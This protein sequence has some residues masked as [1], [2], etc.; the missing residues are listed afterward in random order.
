MIRILWLTVFTWWAM[1]ALAI[2]TAPVVV[3]TT[4]SIGNHAVDP[5]ISEIAVQFDQT[6]NREHW[7]WCGGGPSYPPVEG[8]VRYINETTCVMPV[9]LEPEHTYRF[10]VNCRSKGFQGINGLPAEVTGVWFTTTSSE[11]DYIPADVNNYKAWKEFRR[12]F[13]DVY[14]HYERTGTDWEQ[15]LDDGAE[16]VLRSPNV[17]EWATR[18]SIM[19]GAAQDPHLY[20][21]LQDGSRFSTYG[22]GARYNGNDAAL[23]RAFPTLV[24]HSD[25]V[26]SARQD[27]IGYLSVRSWSNANGELDIIPELLAEMEEKTHALI[28]DVRA[29]GGGGEDLAGK[30]ATWFLEN[31]GV[32]AR[33][34]YRDTESP[35]GWGGIRSRTIA[36]NPPGQ[37]YTSPVFVLQGPVCLSSNEAFLLMMKLAPRGTSI[38]DR[39]GGSSANPRGF[40]LPNGAVIVLPR[41]QSLRPDGTCFEGEGI[42]PDVMITGDFEQEDPVLEEALR[43]ARGGS[44]EAGA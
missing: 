26:W 41:W 11:N 20:L 4:P 6:M 34:R 44:Q 8:E 43:R 13:R 29:N 42:A 19:L 9:K 37:R 35:S 24:R 7:S 18:L 16:W 17:Q 1:A 25:I 31:D 12:L 28:L 22:R 32:Y 3:A 27:G 39:S 23:E 14:S 33:H 36:A 21:R 10:S 5:S 2:D 15:V 38:G 40:D 30:V